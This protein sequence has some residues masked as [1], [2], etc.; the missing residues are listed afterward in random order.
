MSDPDFLTS[1]IRSPWHEGEI[2]LQRRTGVAERLDEIGR[3][4]IRDHLIDQHREFYPLL[5]M[6][7]LGTLDPSERPWATIRS[8]PPGFLSSPDPFRLSLALGPDPAD[9]A[10]AGMA[11]GDPIG[12]LG[13]DLATRRRNRLNGTVRREARG[14]S[15]DV[16]ESFGNCPKYIQQR[17]VQAVEDEV[18]APVVSRSLD[19]A[20]RA[21]VRAADT[22]FVASYSEDGDGRRVDVSHRGGLP[23]FVRVDAE[24][25]LVIPD[26]PGNRFFQTLGNILTT[27]KAG[28][29]FADFETG[30]LLQMTGSAE[31]LEEGDGGFS[32]AERLWRC[33]PEE[34]VSRGAALGLRYEPVEAS[35]FLRGTGW[36]R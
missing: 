26:L 13:I 27:G 12:L 34:V 3:R 8:G 4:V 2:A 36:T 23:G 15:V 6:V 28:L 32:G 9:P 22:F 17:L 31:L 18:A 10:E 7:V 33:K 21:M 16:N 5:P 11:E 14:F 29:V 1:D 25:W 24:G 19:A 30:D 20:A 35:P